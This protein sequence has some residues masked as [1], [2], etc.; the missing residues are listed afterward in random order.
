LGIDT[1]PIKLTNGVYEGLPYVPGGAARQRIEL[2]DGQPA[3][4]VLNGDGDNETVVFLSEQRGG[5]STDLYMALMG[6]VKGRIITLATVRL[7]DRIS[8]RSIRIDKEQVS[9]DLLQSGAKDAACC[10]SELVTRTWSL[11]RTGLV[12][13]VVKKRPGTLALKTL[14]GVQWVFR[15]SIP[16]QAAGEAEATLVFEKDRIS[17]AAGCNRYLGYAATTKV[18]GELT[19]KAIKSSNGECGG[20]AMRYEDQYLEALRQVVRFGFFLGDLTLSWQK[21][22]GSLGTM[23]FAPRKAPAR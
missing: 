5:T 3:T 15:G 16:Q 21:A 9:L 22:D 11:E 8:V 12:E 4:G 18:P 14:E 19:L 2:L 1:N 23:R 13:R 7:G 20:S 17:G 10:P 6:R